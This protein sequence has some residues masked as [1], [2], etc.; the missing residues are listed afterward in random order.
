MR[1][2][3]IKLW[4][5]NFVGWLV[6]N[7]QLSL[8]FG[9]II[10]GAFL[11]LILF[12]WLDSCRSKRTEQKKA[13]I[14]ANVIRANIESEILTNQKTNINGDITNANKNSINALDNFNNSVRRDSNSFPGN[15]A[16]AEDKFC[17]RFCLDSSCFEWRKTHRCLD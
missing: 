10:V 4:I 5:K 3:N 1:L 12:G 13:D 14:G 8:T 17:Q 15:A 6:L 16:R 2:E 7:P 11:F 9:L